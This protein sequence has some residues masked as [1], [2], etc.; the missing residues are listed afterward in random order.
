VSGIEGLRVWAKQ[1]GARESATRPKRSADLEHSAA[2]ID[3]LLPL[4]GEAVACSHAL[5]VL[6][7]LERLALRLF[8][9]SRVCGG[10]RQ[11]LPGRPPARLVPLLAHELALGPLRKLAR[12]LL[13]LRGPGARALAAR[14]VQ[15]GPVPAAPQAEE[16]RQ[17]RSA[18]GWVQARSAGPG[19]RRLRTQHG[20]RE[21]RGSGHGGAGHASRAKTQKRDENETAGLFILE[22]SI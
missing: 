16:L 14:T 6:G 9:C 20:E 12:P 2:G 22:R 7:V 13:L 19:A 21:E 5:Q 15:P 3:S 11:E 17:R 8:F 4:R 1:H 10:L 18:A